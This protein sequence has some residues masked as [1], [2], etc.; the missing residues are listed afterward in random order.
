MTATSRTLVL[1]QGY[2]P[3][4]V[5]S[6]QRA[7]TLLSLGKIE[8]IE[9]Y[10]RELRSTSLVIKCPAVVRLLNAFK[11]HKK[12]VKFSRVNI[13]ARDKYKCQYCGEKGTLQALTY[14]HVRPKSQGGKTVWTNIVTSCTDCNSK[15]R[16]RTPE[17]AGL[18]LRGNPTQPRW[19]P[20]MTIRISHRS[21]PEAWTEYISWTR[22]IDE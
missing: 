2:E 7:I 6:W 14:D 11:R 9:E 3:L 21:A 20:S 18:R 12:P 22:S 4:K 10:D 16:N 19:V 13:F 5:I 17:Q 8:V 15:K 1:T